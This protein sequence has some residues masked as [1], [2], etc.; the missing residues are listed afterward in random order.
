MLVYTDPTFLADTG[1]YSKHITNLPT[2]QGYPNIDNE[3]IHTYVK[4]L[5]IQLIMN[6]RPTH[7]CN[8]SES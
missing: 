4:G 6:T 2:F 5:G 3:Y 7:F 1:K 8:R